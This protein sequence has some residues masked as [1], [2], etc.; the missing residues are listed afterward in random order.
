MATDDESREGRNDLFEI[1]RIHVWRDSVATDE[2]AMLLLQGLIEIG[3]E[4]M[5]DEDK[6]RGTVPLQTDYE[7]ECERVSERGH[8]ANRA[9]RASIVRLMAVYTIASLVSTKYS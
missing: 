7:I 1:Y 3:F 5:S 4:A 9:R 6:Q 8:G 2:D